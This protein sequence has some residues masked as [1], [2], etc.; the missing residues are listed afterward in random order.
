MFVGKG[1]KLIRGGPNIQGAGVWEMAP[2]I[3][4]FGITAENF[5]KLQ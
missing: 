4:G 1:S 5:L 3:G 2:L